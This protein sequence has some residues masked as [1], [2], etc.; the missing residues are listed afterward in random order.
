QREMV[1]GMVHDTV[2]AALDVYL[3]SEIPEE[4]RDHDGLSDWL[5]TRFGVSV[6]PSETRSMNASEARD[7]VL[8][9]INCTY[10]QRESDIAEE[11]MRALERFILLQTIDVKWKDH[12]Y[13][14]DYLK[15]GIGLRGW[16]QVD[17]KMAYKKEGYEMFAN[18]LSSVGTEVAEIIFKVHPEMEGTG[19]TVWHVSGE[20]RE[21]LTHV[22]ADADEPVPEVRE[23]IKRDVPKVG[24]NAPC[25]CG[26]GKK[27]KHCCGK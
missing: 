7:H 10:K 15:S 23:P 6:P 20:G 18:M 11:R 2:N 14:M 1:V 22:F 16:G 26:S 24:R 5:R 9:E 25:P 8:E 27:H 19:R 13:M 4:E 12:L 17:P 3:S 21:E